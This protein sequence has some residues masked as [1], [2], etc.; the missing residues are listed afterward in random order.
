MTVS[1]G[2]EG[3]SSRHN[4]NQTLKLCHQDK[5]HLSSYLFSAHLHNGL[6]LRLCKWKVSGLHLPMYKASRKKKRALRVKVK[7]WL[8]MALPHLGHVPA[9][10]PITVV[11]SGRY[12]QAWGPGQ[13]LSNHRT[14]SEEETKET[15]LL[16]QEDRGQTGC[17]R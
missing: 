8:Q 14:Q 13:P 11:R 3:E 7:S 16:L 6:I 12:A 1:S 15:Q 17:C 5:Q 9:P 2:R 10:E 4:L